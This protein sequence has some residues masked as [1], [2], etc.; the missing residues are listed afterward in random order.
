MRRLDCDC[1][2]VA[3]GEDD[4][5][6]VAIARSHAWE[7]HGVRLTAELILALAQTGPSGVEGTAGDPP[8]TT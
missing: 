7:E 2:Y 8:P 5:T 3:W 4:R 6:L 1:G